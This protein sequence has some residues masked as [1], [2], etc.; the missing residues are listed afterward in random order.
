MLLL[1]LIDGTAA[2]P[3]RAEADTAGAAGMVAVGAAGAG[4]FSAA[5]CCRSC[6]AELK[7]TSS[8]QGGTCKHDTLSVADRLLV[9][10]AAGT[11]LAGLAVAVPATSNM[12]IISNGDLPVQI[13]TAL[14][15]PHHC[16]QQAI[17]TTSESISTSPLLPVTTMQY[18]KV[19]CSVQS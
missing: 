15:P 19:Q 4:A 18:S 6:V 8:L 13:T 9:A 17:A 7:A 3:P 1:S 5:G 14:K 10:R 2:C 12:R 16:C 11:L